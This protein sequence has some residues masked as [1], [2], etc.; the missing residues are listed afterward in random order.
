VTLAGALALAIFACGQDG[1]TSSPGSGGA[2]TAG[3][4]GSSGSSGGAQTGGDAGSAGSTSTG[5][6]A[7]DASP[8]DDLDAAVDGPDPDDRFRD[9]PAN[10]APRESDAGSFDWGKAVVESTLARYPTPQD[11]GPWGYPKGLYLHGQ[12]LVYKRLRDPRYLSY[13][14]TWV[15]MAV[16]AGGNIVNTFTTLDSM[17]PGQLL[18]DLFQET[19]DA[20]YRTAADSIRKRFDTYARTSDGGFLHKESLPGQLWGDGTFMALPF[21]IRYGHLFADDKYADDETSKQF[22]VYHTHLVNPATG[23]L[24]HAYDEQGDAAWNAPGVKH[25]P[26]SWCRAMGWFGVAVIEELELLP[27]AHPRRAELVGIVEGLVAAWAQFQDPVTGRWFQ[28]VDK[29]SNPDNWLE[30]SCSSMYTFTISRAAEK[31]Y[32][33][34]SY[35]DVARKGFAGVMQ[36]V[37][38]GTDG[39]TSIAEI[40][41]GTDVGD[42]AYYLARPRSTNNLHG[43]GAFLIMYE[44]LR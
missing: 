43:V 11:L 13:I 32:V 20:R 18:L 3:A 36:K 37:S 21:L 8:G 12:Y 9:A 10:D 25:S 28:V 17:M 19:K 4:G 33:A 39:R 38:L 24:F 5:G 41:M 29:G 35:A 27:A 1:E 15:D 44:Q 31:G 16:D 34:S 23:L 22:V 6:S 30:T 7:P 26:E 2:A 40:C 14:K 42:L